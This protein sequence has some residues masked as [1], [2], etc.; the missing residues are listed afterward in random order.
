MKRNLLRAF[1]KD[2]SGAGYI[3]LGLSIVPL[4]GM[5]ALGT[6]YVIADQQRTEMQTAVET[7]AL[8]VAKRVAL[9]PNLT[10]EAVVQEGKDIVAAMTDLDIQYDRF[11]ADP[12]TG[13]V[14]IDAYVVQKTHFMH[15]FGHD[16]LI[17]RHRA[18]AAFGRQ[19]VEVAIAID[20]SGSMGSTVGGKTKIQAAKDAAKTLISAASSA[21]EDLSNSDLKFSLVPWHTTVKLPADEVEDDDQ[22]NGY[23]SWIDWAGKSTAHF[24]YLPPYK[25]IAGSQN[26][27]LY[28]PVDGSTSFGAWH[29]SKLKDVLPLEDD[30]KGIDLDTMKAQADIKIVTRKDVFDS[31]SNVEWGRCFEHRAGTYRY[32]FAA[33]NANDGDSLFVPWMAPDDPGSAGSANS[34]LN[35]NAGDYST[36]SSILDT[37]AKKLFNTTKYVAAPNSRT[38][39][40]SRNPNGN[41][42]I[43]E[44]IGLTDDTDAIEDA[45]DD[46]SAGGNTDLTIGLEWAMHTLTPEPPFEEAQDVSDAVKILV[47]MT[48]GDNVPASPSSYSDSYS[49]FQY[50]K[51]NLLGYNWSASGPTSSQATQM[52]DDATKEYCTAIKNRGVKVYFV[53]FGSASSGSQALMNHCASNAEAAIEASDDTE[54]EEAFRKIGDDIGKL[55]LTHYSGGDD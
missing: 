19:N 54:L 36:S 35:D 51:D 33:P 5:V 20:N 48:D 14:K 52:F 32:S 34:Y 1:R 38:A 18:Q 46:M 50:P 47:I 25:E 37:T 49:S 44:M 21:M 27:T 11:T 45:I 15:F 3:M 17:A 30:G 43:A 6:D 4:F 53:Y 39:S 7:V 10:E 13:K 8:H 41:C 22:P 31:F 40:G 2:E 28:Y 26:D 23:K 12:A 16:N 29:P 42:V 9:N 24:A 55:R